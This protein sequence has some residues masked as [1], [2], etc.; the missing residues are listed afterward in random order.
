[1][2]PEGAAVIGRTSELKQFA[3]RI[4]IQPETRRENDLE[5]AITVCRRTGRIW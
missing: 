4:G 1:L 2:K 3:E 5:A